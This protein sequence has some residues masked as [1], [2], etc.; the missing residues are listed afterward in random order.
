[1][2][3]A[4]EKHVHNHNVLSSQSTY[5]VGELFSFIPQLGEYL[6]A[7]LFGD[8]FARDVLDWRAREI[9]TVAALA[10][11]PE[12]E[13]QVFAY[14]EIAMNNGVTKEKEETSLG[15]FDVRRC[16]NYR[17]QIGLRFLSANLIPL[18]LSFL[19]V[20]VT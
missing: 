1:M 15:V 9:V 3:D 6:K 11:R 2:I 13:P 4:N 17:P 12:T 7:R 16:P 5:I 8:I 14:L 18:M 10:A 20:V 19:L